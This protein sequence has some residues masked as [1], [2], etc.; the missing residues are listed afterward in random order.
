M[1]NS[2]YHCLIGVII[3]MPMKSVAMAEPSLIVQVINRIFSLSDKTRV[4]RQCYGK[5]EYMYTVAQLL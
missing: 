3:L 5:M 4:F 2:L 1:K